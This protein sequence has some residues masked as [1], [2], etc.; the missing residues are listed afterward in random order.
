M[1]HFHNT[2]KTTIHTFFLVLNEKL[3]LLNDH[4]SIMK[5]AND[6]REENILLTH[7]CANTFWSEYNELSLFLNHISA[8]LIQIRPCSTS[9]E[10]IE[11]EQNK[12][13]QLA[14]DFSNQ[15][16]K[17]QEFF[18][19]H[20]LQLLNLILN[21]QQETEDIQRCIHELEQQL[22][23][24][25]TDL[26]ICQKELSEAMIKSVEFN[27]KLENVQIWFDDKSNL[28]TT[29]EN[30][31][32]F[33]HIRIFKEHLDNKYIDIINLK[34]DY[35]DIEQQNEYVIEEQLIEMDSKWTQLNEQIQEQ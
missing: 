11:H 33:E 12:Y 28:T 35:T 14:T 9:C 6:L 32:E 15:Q 27:S 26:T 7:K 16:I 17:F 34:Q 18:Q 21:N 31:D 30:N 10:Y 29:V 23:R 20:S 22:N 5:Q 3:S 19:Q 25:Q 4:W 2:E 1:N 8:Q 13:N 24:I